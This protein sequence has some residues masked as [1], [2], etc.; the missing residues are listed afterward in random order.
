MPGSDE[1]RDPVELELGDERDDCVADDRQQDDPRLHLVA[2]VL[3]AV[4]ERAVAEQML[5]RRPESR[6]H[7]RP[8][9]H[10]PRA[11][12]V[13][14]E[15]ALVLQPEHKALGKE[16]AGTEGEPEPFFEV[17]AG[18]NCEAN[19]NGC[20]PAREPD[21]GVG[22]TENGTLP[23]AKVLATLHEHAEVAGRFVVWICRLSELLDRQSECGVPPDDTGDDQPDRVQRRPR[24]VSP[25]EFVLLRL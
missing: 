8:G 16:D 25:L 12:G 15:N 23:G 21:D 11:Q 22:E 1:G 4:T 14:V 7:N 10:A 17:C 9:D 5:E 2:E 20:N 13:Q 3:E 6:N 19:N 18:E 24:L